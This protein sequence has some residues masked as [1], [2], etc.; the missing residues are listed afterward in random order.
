[1]L[2]KSIS[3][4]ISTIIFIGVFPSIAYATTTDNYYYSEYK[5]LPDTD[6]F[7][8]AEGMCLDR[9]TNIIYVAKTNGSKTRLYS[10]KSGNSSELAPMTCNGVKSYDLGHA[11]DLTV[12]TENGET[13]IYVAPAPTKNIETKYE[14]KIVKLKV[15]GN[16]FVVDHVYDSSIN[17]S[18]ITYSVGTGKFIIKSGDDFYIGKF[19]DKEFIAEKTFTLNYKVQIG[20]TQTDVS[21]YL[22]QGMTY[23]KGNLYVPFTK[24][25]V[26]KNPLNVSVVAVYPLDLNNVKNGEQLNSSD[27]LAYRI[28]SKTYN[29][30]EIEAVAFYNG[31]AYF[32]ANRD[33]SEK[34]IIGIFKE[35]DK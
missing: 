15:K 2:K 18:G 25:D 3:L 5:K 35:S 26:N 28:N 8:G 20:N 13:Y 21:D 9:D 31:V 23:Y 4:L 6:G 33:G 7:T 22:K 17:A 1:M 34:D 32:D 11:N 14:N 12:A 30:F 27:K 19:N 16:T 10:I 24:E 29:K